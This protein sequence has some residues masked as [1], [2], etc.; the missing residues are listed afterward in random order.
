LFNISVNAP[1]QRAPRGKKAAVQ[2]PRKQH[3][4]MLAPPPVFFQPAPS[5]NQLNASFGRRFVPTTEED[6]EFRLTVE[7]MG[8]KRNFSVFQDATQ[9][10]PA[11]TETPLEDDR[12][13]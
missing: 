8:K 12:Y 10:S 7:D 4:P 9:A 11:R 5:L 13:V 2:S 3:H 1:R 6:E